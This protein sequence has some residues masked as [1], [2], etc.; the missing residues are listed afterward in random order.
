M[1]V[2]LHV[3]YYEGAGKFET[4]F[5]I[6]RMSGADGVELRAT[7][8]YDMTREQYLAM[9]EELK[10]RNSDLEITFGYPLHFSSINDD[11]QKKEFY[12]FHKGFVPNQEFD[13]R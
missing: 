5:K 3:N 13:L 8:Y 6:I 12:E 2:L 10:Q 9:V 1:K 11:E 4:L 7:D